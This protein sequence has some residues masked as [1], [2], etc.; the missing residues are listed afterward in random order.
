MSCNDEAALI[1]SHYFRSLARAAGVRWTAHNDA[2]MQRVA[3]LLGDGGLVEIPGFAQLDA[4]QPPVEQP[5]AR[6]LAVPGPRKGGIA[7]TTTT[8]DDRAYLRRL[9]VANGV[10]TTARKRGA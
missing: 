1:L 6:R 5:P 4:D 3:D 9:N 2:D 7:P 8:E 10:E